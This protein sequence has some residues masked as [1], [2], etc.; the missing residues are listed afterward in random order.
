MTESGGIMGKRNLGSHQEGP[1]FLVTG[2]AGFIGSHLVDLILSK[3][4]PVIVVDDF[5]SGS[6]DN[7]LGVL[8]HPLLQLIRRS[9][10]DCLNDV[11]IC[12]VIM[13]RNVTHVVHLAAQVSLERSYL[14]PIF[15]I[16]SNYISTVQVV[17]LAKKLKVRKLVFA[18]TAAVYGEF[19]GGPLNEN[20]SLSPVSP[21]GINKRASESY[22]MSASKKYSIP[23]CA[24]RF[25]NVYGP[26]QNP[27]SH[28]SGVISKFIRNAVKGENLV[29]FG[30]GGQTRDFI[31]VE[32]ISKGIY[33]AC[34]EVTLLQ[35]EILN[36]G[37][38]IST[39]ILEL[40]QLVIKLSGSQSQ[41]QIQPS[42][43]GGVRHSRAD[44]T[45]KEILFG[46]VQMKPLELGIKE[47]LEWNLK[48]IMEEEV[49]GLRSRRP[50][51]AP[52]I[53]SQVG[54]GI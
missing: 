23:A 37:T 4:H 14:E 52:L 18:S 31:S 28:Y 17:D 35:G 21:Y 19:E 27:S 3:G 53:P 1:V 39:S 8:C 47:T 13:E 7:L 29:I 36:F 16:E 26:R 24:L 42:K 32:D 34:N 15:D 54:I 12:K 43:Q 50:S 40:A 9:I 22:L 2:G 41:I 51:V 38:G 46:A 45:K 25:F 20:I 48:V 6:I 33:S 30:D 44:L 10:H 49:I 11:E 5:R